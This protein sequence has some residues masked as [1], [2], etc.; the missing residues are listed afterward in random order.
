[1]RMACDGEKGSGE[2]KEERELVG[3][4]TSWWRGEEQGEK[5]GGDEMST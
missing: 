3:R 5:K 2:G 1:M 4:R